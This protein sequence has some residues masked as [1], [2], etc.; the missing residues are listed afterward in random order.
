[1]KRVPSGVFPVIAIDRELPQSLYQ[2]IYEGYRTTILEDRLRAGQ[3]VPST[4][5]LACELGISRIPVLTAYA[6]LLAEGYF[7]S[8]VG[9]GT[10]VSRSLPQRVAPLP[11]VAAASVPDRSRRRPSRRALSFPGRQEHY[12]YPGLGPFGEGQVA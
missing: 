10:V 1:M 3:R 6:Q 4:R 12:R 11:P 8:R 2:Q 9:S 5:V 7:E